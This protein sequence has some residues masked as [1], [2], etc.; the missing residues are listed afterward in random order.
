MNEDRRMGLCRLFIQKCICIA[1]FLCLSWISNVT[2][3]TFTDQAIVLVS[4]P[5]QTFTDQAIVLVGSPLQTFTDQAIVLIGSP[6]QTF[7]Q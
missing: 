1:T 2:L 6:L 7:T 3:Q 4:S 5:L